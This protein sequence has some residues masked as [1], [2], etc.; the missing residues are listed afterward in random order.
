MKFPATPFRWWPGVFFLFFCTLQGAEQESLAP[1]GYELAFS[2][3]F[4]NPAER[5]TPEGNSYFTTGNFRLNGKRDWNTVRR[6]A[7]NEEQ[8]I[9]LDEEASL[10]GQK[11][12]INPFSIKEGILSI[13]ARP[14]SEEYR[15]RLTQAYGGPPVRYSS[16]ML[17]TETD[18]RG[19]KGFAQRYGYW[20]LR[21]R[22]PKGKGIWPAFWLV[23]ETHDF[24]DE[25]DVF[26]VLGHEPDRIYLTTHLHKGGGTDGVEAERK[27][28]RGIDTSDGFHVYGM[29][30][31][32]GELVY[33]IDHRE[34]LRVPHSL[35]KPMYAI[36]NLAVGGAW[37]GNPG[38]TTEFPAIMEIDYLRIYRPK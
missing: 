7:A 23:G 9:Y 14:L 16:G 30:I 25:V 35:E 37:P 34:V 3:E 2:A 24:W 10:G 22:L 13:T 19:G 8:Q 27:E 29:E 17:S 12:G 1:Q 36:I 15:E 21:A 20:E 18:G 6:L 28:V 32:P 31:K 4:E 26:E 5:F 33:S 38:E 11:L